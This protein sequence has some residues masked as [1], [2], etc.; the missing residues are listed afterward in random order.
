MCYPNFQFTGLIESYREVV[1]N[2]EKEID[3]P[4]EILRI[5]NTMVAGENPIF[6]GLVVKQGQIEC[7][8]T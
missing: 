6:G 4:T 8:A 3:V 5:Y 1:P 7:T 2:M